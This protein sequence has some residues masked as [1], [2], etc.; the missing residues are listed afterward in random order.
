MYN[1]LGSEYEPEL[2][3]SYGIVSGLPETEGKTSE[4]APDFTVTDATGANVKL[5]DF[6]GK[7]VV[8][9]F[10][11]SWCSPCK[12]EMPDFD[13]AFAMY[14]EDV[15]F[16]M[17]N[18]TNANGETAEKARALIKQEGYSFP[19]YFDTKSLADRAYGVTSIPS[20]YFIDKDGKIVASYSGSMEYNV[21]ERGIKAVIE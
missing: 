15:H 1:K 18:L 7:P 3:G 20:T 2:P 5:S 14:G 16:L 10:W 12:S 17:V 8:L 9:N 21:L 19:V 13:K 4:Y 11:A 6:K